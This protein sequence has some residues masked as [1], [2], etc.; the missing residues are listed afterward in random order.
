MS[1]TSSSSSATPVFTRNLGSS[2]ASK[3]HE[4][5]FTEKPEV[6]MRDQIIKRCIEWSPPIDYMEIKSILLPANVTDKSQ[7]L[8]YTRRWEAYLRSH[9]YAMKF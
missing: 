9:P 7:W 2:S 3:T 1:N 4:L 5:D 6:D 8:L